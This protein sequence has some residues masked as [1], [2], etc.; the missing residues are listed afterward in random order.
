[1]ADRAIDELKA[2]GWSE[3]EARVYLAL[4]RDG[5][6][7][8]GYQCAKLARLPRANVYP[9]LERLVRRGAVVEVPDQAA[10]QY[11]AVA[12]RDLSRVVVASVQ[13][14]LAA[15]GREL[16]GIPDRPRI[17]RSHGR[18]AF[19]REGTAA[20]RDAER[21]VDVGASVGTV[22]VFADVLADARARGVV[23]AY[24]CFDRCPPPGCG[25]C[26]DPVPVGGGPFT[27]HGWLTLLTD[28]RVAV[29]ATN[30][31][32]DPEVL[33][34]DLPPLVETLRLLFARLAKE[35]SFR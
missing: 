15:V 29:V 24:Y 35:R 16:S 32:T 6:P 34:T 28:D 7:R 13:E 25:V 23:T 19:R 2:L 18:L 26:V 11:Q 1:M 17:A 33:R 8:T 10:T 9:A 14:H 5:Q 12:F 3:A 30:V 27:L 31:G 20:I 21:T 22:D 4:H